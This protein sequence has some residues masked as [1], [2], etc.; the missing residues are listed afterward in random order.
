M[1]SWLLSFSQLFAPVDSRTSELEESELSQVPV[2]ALPGWAYARAL[3]LKAEGD[4][5]ASQVRQE[6]LY[7]SIK[8]AEI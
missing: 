4:Q 8:L 6:Y 2:V 7:V 5:N 3:A 1:H